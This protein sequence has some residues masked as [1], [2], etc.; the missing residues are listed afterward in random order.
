MG[1]GICSPLG[2][3]EERESDLNPLLRLRIVELYLHLPIVVMA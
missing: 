2:K 3:R 1:T